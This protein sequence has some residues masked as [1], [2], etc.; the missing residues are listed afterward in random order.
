M[1][2]M[3]LPEG[4]HSWKPRLLSR[5]PKASVTSPVTE[6]IGPGTGH[7]TAT[8]DDRILFWWCNFGG[9]AGSVAGD[10]PPEARLYPNA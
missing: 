6:F 2:K 5:S 8:M 1:A 3:R 7:F 10:T 4:V 9:A